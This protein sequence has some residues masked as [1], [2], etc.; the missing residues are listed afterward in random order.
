M[1][2]GLVTLVSNSYDALTFI[3]TNIAHSTCSLRIE[4]NM[5]RSFFFF[6]FLFRLSRKSK[7]NG[8]T[9][10]MRHSHR[11][12]VSMDLPPLSLTVDLQIT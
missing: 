6:R 8:L 12:H 3:L 5:D 9:V 4:R 10:K 2:F 1:R 7:Q 11:R